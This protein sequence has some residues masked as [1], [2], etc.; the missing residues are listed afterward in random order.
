[1]SPTPVTVTTLRGPTPTAPGTPPA[2]GTLGVLPRTSPPAPPRRASTPRSVRRLRRLQLAAVALLLAFGAF[3][4]TAL[5]VSFN[6]AAHAAE[7]LT[8]YHRLADARVQALRVQ[9]SANA[10]ALTP[11]TAVRDQL[12]D[13]LG[14]LAT[15]LADAAGVADDRDRVVPLTGALVNYAMTL[16]NALNADGTSS[17]A[18]ASKA[19]DQLAIDLITPLEAA[20]AAA[21]DRVASDLNTNWVYWVAGAAVLAVGALAAIGVALARASH[22][23]LNIGVA[24]GLL[25]AVVSAVVVWSVA[26]AASSVAFDFTDSSRAD[27]DNIAVARQQIHQARADELLAIGLQSDGGSYLTQWT[28]GYTAATSAVA[29]VTKSSKVTKALTTYN[30][31]HTTVANLIAKSQWAQASNAAIGSSGAGAEAFANLDSALS[32]L[33]TTLRSPVISS[34]TGVGNAVISGIAGVILLTL[35]GAGLTFWGVARRIEEYR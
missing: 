24:A 7:S 16:Q 20:T 29:E 2:P 10:W 28:A 11:T 18:I 32:T 30:T 14:T 25:C 13:Q 35:A 9:Q 12:D 8:Q 34:V 33:N 19:N 6:A 3:A 27:L 17:A 31:A 15:T 21:G 23:Y 1:M 5:A 22:R 26:G 4:I